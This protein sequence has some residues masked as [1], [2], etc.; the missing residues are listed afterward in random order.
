MVCFMAN[1]LPEQITDRAANTCL[2]LIAF[3]K[4]NIIYENGY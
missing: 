1:F 3:F 2:I 4:Y